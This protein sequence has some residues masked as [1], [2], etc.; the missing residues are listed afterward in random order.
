VTFAAWASGVA[1]AGLGLLVHTAPAAG[2]SLLAL[3]AM[4][5]LVGGVRLC[6]ITS[7]RRWSVDEPALDPVPKRHAQH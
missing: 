6:S 5:A 1:A 4:L 2:T 3:T 7:V